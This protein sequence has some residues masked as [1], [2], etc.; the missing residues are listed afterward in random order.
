[1]RILYIGGFGRSGSTLLSRLLGEV[2]NACIAGEVVNI[3][4]YGVI[5]NELC[6]CG[7]PF[8]T[9]AFWTA[10]GAAAFGGWNKSQA[11]RVLQARTLCD[12]MRMIPL[13]SSGQLTPTQRS[14]LLVYTDAHIAVCTAVAQVSGAEV[15]I[16]C[17]KHVPI[18]HSLAIRTGL[19]IRV[20]HLIRDSR[21]VAY[22]WSKVR[23]R[24]ESGN[25]VTYM[26]RFS[27]ISSAAL[28]NRHNF[29]LELLSRRRLP[30]MQVR[31]ED[32]VDNPKRKLY[33]LCQFI[34][35][36]AGDNSF[37][38]LADGY[39]VLGRSHSIGGNPMRFNHGRTQL[40]VDDA[41]RQEL[42]RKD[43]YLVSMITSPL[44]ARYGYLRTW[45]ESRTL[46]GRAA[47]AEGGAVGSGWRAG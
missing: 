31:Y 29:G 22:S 47:A 36:D 3:F 24:P 35:L 44:L 7:S 13:L 42:P 1:M 43:R 23:R 5:W 32:V 10:V 16:D 15:V 39:A 19:D 25:S 12:R 40:T 28:W 9:C 18:A 11:V 8:Y 26:D 30:K 41:W 20:I 45:S 33:E 2:G 34:G 27:A 4:Q 46:A 38:F 17:S 14:A 21:G 6:D 37:G